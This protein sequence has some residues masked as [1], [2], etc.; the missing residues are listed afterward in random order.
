MSVGIY[1]GQV[2]I[3][4]PDDWFRQQGYPRGEPDVLPAM[5]YEIK[6]NGL[7]YVSKP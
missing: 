3:V 1:H 7:E 6:L 2:L 4:L 5:V